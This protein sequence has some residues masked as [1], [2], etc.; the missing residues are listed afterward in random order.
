MSVSNVGT[1]EHLFR[2][3]HLVTSAESD[4]HASRLKFYADESFEVTE[5]IREHVA[6]QGIVLTVVELKDHPWYSAKRCYE[7]LGRKV[8]GPIEDSWESLKS[9][10]NNIPV[11]VKQYA[12]GAG[13]VKLGAALKQL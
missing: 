9:L 3:Q 6:A 1:D 4:V 13:D 5:E 2:V 8:W 12:A 7:I 11:M 10:Y